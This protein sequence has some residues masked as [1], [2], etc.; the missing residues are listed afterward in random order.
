MPQFRFKK[1]EE[2]SKEQFLLEIYKQAHETR[3]KWEGYIWQ[4][5]F[6]LTLLAAL[7]ASG[8]A[9]LGKV[10]LIHKLVLIVLTAFLFSIFLNV[11]RGRVLMKD[12][13]KTIETIH[14]LIESNLPVTPRELDQNSR[15]LGRW[16]STKVAACCHFGAFLLF[17]GI[18]LYVW[19]CK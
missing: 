16:P 17:F 6:L 10:I 11:L 9:A 1:D 19:I 7:F 18:T 14:G 3:R 2:L 4:W 5:G 13:E 15:G 8:T 12:V